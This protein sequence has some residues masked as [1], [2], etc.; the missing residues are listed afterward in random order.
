MS[1]PRRIRRIPQPCN[2]L[3][4]LYQAWLRHRAQSATRKLLWNMSDERLKDIGLAR[5]DIERQYT[6]DYRD[7]TLRHR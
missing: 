1:I 6:S 3:S 5:G 7:D 2:W 4:A